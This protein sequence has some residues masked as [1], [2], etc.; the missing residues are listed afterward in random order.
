MARRRVI[1]DM[2]TVHWCFFHARREWSD[3][4]CSLVVRWTLPDGR[5]LELR[6]EREQA[7]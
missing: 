1:P 6:S 7:A 4:V 3:E 5:P 2:L